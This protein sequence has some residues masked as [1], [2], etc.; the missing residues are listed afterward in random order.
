CPEGCE[1]VGRRQREVQCVDGQKGRPLR[2]FHCQALSSRPPSTLSCHP[3]PC[4]PWRTSP[5]GQVHTHTL[6]HV[7]WLGPNE[8]QYD[9]EYKLFHPQCSR[10]CGGGLRE[11][12]VYCPEPQRCNA[13]Q[14]PND[15]E[16]CNLQPCSYWD[17]Q[18]WEKCS[19]SCGG[20]MQ[21]RVVPCVVED[22]SSVE[23]SLCDQINMP[24]TLRTCNLQECK[25]N[26]GLLCRKNS[27][28][29]RFCDKLKL[30]GRCSLRSIQ[31]QCCVT[32]R[33]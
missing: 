8:L 13:T 1:V 10:S 6:S 14:R 22:S 23:N 26:T 12:L 19:V 5:W 33:G 17:P 25:T 16:T 21:H 11:R 27:M 15:T 28:S 32:C 24:D 30:L 7:D 4:Q 31:K 3:Q 20:G 29:S 2:P 18:D 9:C